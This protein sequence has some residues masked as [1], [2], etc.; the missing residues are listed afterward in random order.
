MN[1]IWKSL[2]FVTGNSNKLIEAGQILG[3]PLE[4][5]VLQELDE[6]QTHNV[7]EVVV[8]KLNQ[9]YHKLQAPVMVED[10]GLIFCAWNGL[11]GALVKWFEISVGCG[12]LVK[13]LEPFS[14][15][16]AYAVC[17]VGVHDGGE[18]KIAKGE[19]RGNIALTERG[20]NG[21]GWDSIFIPDGHVRTFA[22][23]NA[24]EKNAI[25]HRKKAFEALRA[26]V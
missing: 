14:D 11:P 25:S 22:E 16:S 4:Q 5:A 21:F 26:M 10:S 8:H 13:M 18:T 20:A 6:L 1:N 9:A 23:M 19:V 7:E 12:G 3:I 15:R 24:V 17:Y 2:K